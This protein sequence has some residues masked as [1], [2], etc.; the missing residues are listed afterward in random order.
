M[1]S[2]ILCISFLLCIQNV[3]IAQKKTYETEEILNVSY[4]NN[5]TKDSIYTKLNIVLPKGIENPPVLMWLGGGA[6]AYVDRHKQMDLSRNLAK[7]GIAVISVGH[8]LSPALLEG[9]PKRDSGVK[10]PEH[11]KDVAKAFA[12]IYKNEKK[13]NYD[14]NNIFVGGYSC[15]A[16]L[17]AL[18]A[19]DKKYVEAL[20]LKTNLIKGIIPIAGAYN[21]PLYKKLLEEV[22]PNYITNHINPVFGKSNSE[23][24]EASPLTYVEHLTMPILL[25]NEG[26][27]YIYNGDFEERIIQNGNKNFEVINLYDQ[28]HLSLWTE[29]SENPNSINRDLITA[30]ITKHASKSLTQWNTFV[31]RFVESYK[32][33]NIPILKASYIENIEA[34]QRTEEL[35]KQENFFRGI[36]KELP[37]YATVNLSSNDWLDYQLINYETELN[38]ERIEIEKQWS[39]LK[40]DSISKLG[41]YHVPLAKKW[42]PYFLKKWIDIEVSPDELFNFGLKEVD[43]VT[44]KIEDIQKKLEMDNLTFEKHIS[45][46]SFFY[47]NEREVQKAFEKK[48]EIVDQKTKELFPYLEEIDKVTISKGENPAMAKVPAFYNPFSKVFYY[49]YFDKPYNKRQI[50]WTYIHE[51]IP[52][53]HYQMSLEKI[54]SRSEVQKLF[55]YFGYIEG[56]AAYV[57]EIGYDLEAYQTIYDELGKWEWDL[58]R[59]VRVPLDIGINYYGWDDTKA[60]KFWK[61]HIHGKDDIALRE[62]N[63]IKQWPAQVITYKYGADK[64]LQLKQLAVEEKDF[65]MKKFHTKILENGVLPISILKKMFHKKLAEK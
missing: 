27:T 31:G 48:Q 56:Y 53:H 52:G 28:T 16:H 50:G 51:G 1:I 33:F 60:L 34:V 59:S 18:L 23:H 39:K 17:S 35:D 24:I 9:R 2:R 37:K 41:I 55:E 46:E 15:G 64:L 57:E 7:Q 25:I 40:P 29:L 22:N 38:L 10:H 32:S 36:Q 43:R 11:I 65:S 49:N 58:I 61:Q 8:R 14:T 47:S 20:G 13:Y 3:I 6:W 12:W 63:R 19:A 62:I 4:Y 5:S 54:L 45:Q 42:Y 26:Q 21:I 44:S 30:F